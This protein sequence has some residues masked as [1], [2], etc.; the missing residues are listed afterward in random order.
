MNV[1]EVDYIEVRPWASRAARD[2][3]D[4]ADTPRTRWWKVDDVA[5]AGLMLVGHGARV[6][7]VYVDP[8]FRGQGI[9]TELTEYVLAQC[10]G[11][12]FIEA[13]AWN[14]P[15]YEARGFEVIGGNRHGAKR[16][17]KILQR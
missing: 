13:Y 5:C 1:R 8:A 2:H 10:A 3:V 16:V 6:K 4:L 7:G 9:G 14:A 12:D 17:R 15:W 11:L